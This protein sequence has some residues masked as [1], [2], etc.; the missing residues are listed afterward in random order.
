[1]NAQDILAQAAG[2]I[3]QRSQVY[4]DMQ[5]NLQLAADIASLRLGRPI[6]PYEIA[7]MMVAAKNARAFV[8]PDHADSHIDAAVYEIFAQ[9]LADDYIAS[10]ARATTELRFRSKAEQRPAAVAAL[11][12]DSAAAARIKDNVE[13]MLAALPSRV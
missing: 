8:T 1:M 11:K 10:D 3:D 2:I 4:G 5:H 13:A 12:S 6:H 9:L 7:V